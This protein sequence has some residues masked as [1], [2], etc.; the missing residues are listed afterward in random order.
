MIL[1]NAIIKGKTTLIFQDIFASFNLSLLL[2]VQRLSEWNET[3]EKTIVNL[4]R[5]YAVCFKGEIPVIDTS[6]RI[7]F[8]WREVL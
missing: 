6:H 8:L 4:Y 3:K 2:F 5:K 1:S 7:K